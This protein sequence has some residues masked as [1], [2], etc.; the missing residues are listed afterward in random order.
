MDGLKVEIKPGIYWIGVNDRVKDLFEGIWPLP[1]GISYNSYL[2]IDEKVAVIDGVEEGFSQE[3]YENIERLIDPSKIDYVISN[4]MEPD[5]SGSLPFIR[6]MVPEA[7]IVL[8][9][10][11]REMLNDFYGIR[12]NVQTVGDGDEI[13]LGE[14]TLRFHEIPYVHWPE[15]MVTYLMEEKVLFSGD[16]FGTYGALDG[17][18]FDDQVDVD[19]YIDEMLRYYANII[20]MYS[21]PV[22]NALSKLGGLS[23][24][25]IAPAHGPIWRQDIGRVIGLYDRW[26]H[27]EGEKGV[28][29]IYGSM[30]GNTIEAMEAVGRGVISGGCPTLRIYDVSRTSFS[31]LLQECWH[32]KGVIL[33]APTY[34]TG[35]FI[36]MD[37]LL[38]SLHHKR[39]KNRICGLFG[40]FTWSGGAMR[41]M[42]GI[43]DE[44][45][46]EV[47]E[48][49]VPFK[50]HA[51]EEHLEQLEAL[52]R[53]VAERVMQD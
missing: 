44:L 4:H 12:E 11:A 23:M 6:R 25:V 41:K 16:A 27:W 32:W 40:S 43:L 7:T 42:R 31:I 15:T 49:E 46:W 37:N 38:S 13:S 19:Y 14:R 48:P 26:S 36:P 28:A 17:G 29:L 21:I 20:G 9:E 47:V 39:L 18:F 35:I 10:K 1:R 8:S 30:Y 34:D 33:G 45:K 3:W 24:D 51:T 53:A 5:H 52:G 2:V 22:Q 50:S